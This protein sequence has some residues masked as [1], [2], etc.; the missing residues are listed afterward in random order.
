VK[1]VNHVNAAYQLY[2]QDGGMLVTCID[3][4]ITDTAHTASWTVTW[5]RIISFACAG[6]TPNT[7]SVSATYWP[8]TT[9]I[10]CKRSVHTR[11]K[12]RMKP[13]AVKTQYFL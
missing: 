3:D 2:A 6:T 1:N 13:T 9:P 11:Q 4:S 8:T 12:V 7:I 5:S 10:S